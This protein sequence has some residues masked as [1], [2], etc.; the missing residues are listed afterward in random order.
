MEWPMAIAKILASVTG[1]AHDE[2]VIRNAVAMARPFNAHVVA[3]FVRPDLAEAIAFFSDG[4]SGAVVDEVI[5][6]SRDAAEEAAR[7]VEQTLERVC[8]AEK[9][10]ILSAPARAGSVTLSLREAQGN[11]S[12]QITEAARLS[13]IVVFGPLQN[14]DK[15]GLADAFVQTLTDTDRP[16]LLSA[17]EYQ[18][19][20]GKRIAIGWDG[21]TAA[22]QA[23]S[24]A[25]PYLSGAESVEILSVRRGTAAPQPT[26]ALREYLML[27]GI[28]CTERVI[29]RG[30]RKTGE[31]LLDAAT[32]AADLL[33][34]G[35][36]GHSR[37]RESL[38]GG[39]TQ[40]VITHAKL[41]VFMVH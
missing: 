40:H 30:S 17:E 14:G 38:I 9:V 12:D 15:I 21:K 32:G 34:V 20:F 33:V 29:E 13:D 8:G 4:V 2:A 6:A 41:P 7:R 5:S 10:E 23:V 37:I 26:E 1:G 25:L 11:L 24:G 19:G 31:V 27:H 22:S 28:S 3:I 36:Y 18:T 16:V 39:V 35:G